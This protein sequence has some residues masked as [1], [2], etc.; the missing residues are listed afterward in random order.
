MV[1]FLDFTC[2]DFHVVTCILRRSFARAPARAVFSIFVVLILMMALIYR[3][4]REL[5]NG[6]LFVNFDY[7]NPNGENL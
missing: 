1:A 6:G 2:T 4:S 7:L 5:S 3:A